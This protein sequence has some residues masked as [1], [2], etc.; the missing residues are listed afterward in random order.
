MAAAAKC[1]TRAGCGRD[2]AADDA[3]AADEAVP[4]VDHVHRAGATAAG[5]GLAAHQLGGERLRFGPLRE[6][7]PVAAVGG[8]HPVPRVEHRADP[9]GDRLLPRVEVY[10]AVDLATQEEALHRLLEVAQEQHPAVA[11]EQRSGV[12]G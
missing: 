7:G 4:E 6:S 12:G 5:A 11:V 10:G 9:D 1:Q 2:A 3:E 8:G